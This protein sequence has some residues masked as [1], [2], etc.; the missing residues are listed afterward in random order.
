MGYSCRAGLRGLV[1]R[2]RLNHLPSTIP[3]PERRIGTNARSA[4]SMPWVSYSIPRGVVS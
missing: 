2:N 3:R 4:G 1:M